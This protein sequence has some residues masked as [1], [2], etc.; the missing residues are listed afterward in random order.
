VLSEEAFECSSNFKRVTSSGVTCLET[1][2]LEV[3]PA[4]APSL[5]A[6]R[7]AG[8]M[9]YD[10]NYLL[11]C[12]CFSRCLAT[13]DCQHV[14]F[15]S[16]TSDSSAKCQLFSGTCTA[17]AHGSGLLA[18]L[19]RKGDS[20]A[21][22][23]L[24]RMTCKMLGWALTDDR[25]P[26]MTCAAAGVCDTHV[27]SNVLP[28]GRCNRK[29]SGQLE[30][31]KAEEFCKVL[32]A[33]LCEATEIMVMDLKASGRSC[34]GD[35]NVLSDVPAW[36]ASKWYVSLSFVSSSLFLL[37]SFTLLSFTF[38]LLSDVSLSLSLPLPLP[39]SFSFFLSSVLRTNTY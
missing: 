14:V 35:F 1:P 37:L 9:S 12:D 34:G 29:C 23:D 20:S 24:S 21:A 10:P 17:V 38:H 30:I 15:V 2:L 6:F 4:K 19:F 39:L 33:R 8:S 36:T 18:T 28:G 32:G 3:K 11:R 13:G 5:A 22:A 31:S 7:A 16:P 25:M 27:H 26:Q